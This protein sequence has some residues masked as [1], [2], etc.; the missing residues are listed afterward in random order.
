MGIL[1]DVLIGT[2]V[3]GMLTEKTVPMRREKIM[4]AITSMRHFQIRVGRKSQ[5]SVSL[6]Y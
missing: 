1:K 5:P 4:V 6:G 3:S 2:L